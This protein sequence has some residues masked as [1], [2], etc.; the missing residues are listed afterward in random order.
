MEG[1]R[2]QYVTTPLHPEEPRVTATATVA[3]DVLKP[4]KSTSSLDQ[5]LEKIVPK[6]ITRR[7]TSKT[8]EDQASAKNINIPLEVSVDRN[9]QEIKLQISINLK[10]NL[11]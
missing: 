7:K 3:V 1:P 8:F 6:E 2:Q 11:G 4:R 5:E 10:I 9:G